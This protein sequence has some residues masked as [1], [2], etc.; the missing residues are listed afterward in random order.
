M[1]FDDKTKAYIMG[2]VTVLV[3]ILLFVVCLALV[4]SITNNKVIDNKK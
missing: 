1:K 3:S 2:A 4:N